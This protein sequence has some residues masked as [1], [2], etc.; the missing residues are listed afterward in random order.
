MTWSMNWERYNMSLRRFQLT[1]VRGS[2]NHGRD[3]RDRLME[4]EV[5]STLRA[6]DGSLTKVVQSAKRVADVDERERVHDYTAVDDPEAL[7]I[8]LPSN[9]AATVNDL[10]TKREAAVSR[11]DLPRG[12][13]ADPVMTGSSYPAR[14]QPKAL[15]MRSGLMLA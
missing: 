2:I 6:A 9:S 10:C 4:L 11:I 1:G 5:K 7:V 3:L 12:T 13:S 8:G 14:E 15:L